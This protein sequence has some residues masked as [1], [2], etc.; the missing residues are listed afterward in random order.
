MSDGHTVVRGSAASARSAPALAAMAGALPNDEY[1]ADLLVHIAGV[2]FGLVG[3]ITLIG[4][5]AAGDAVLFASTAIY[6]LGLIAMLGCSCA[7][8]VSCPLPKTSWLR[9]ADHAA[10]FLMIAGSITPFALQ[11]EPAWRIA[12]LVLVW[13]IAL[14]AAAMKLL[15]PGRYEREMVYVYVALGWS[16]L[17]LLATRVGELPREAAV[18]LVTGVVIYTGG[19]FFHL[20]EKLR[21]GRA[22][23]HACVLAAAVCHYIAIRDGVVLSGLSQFGQA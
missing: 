13:S 3:A 12:G 1:L 7:Y 8:N 23:W 20:C 15:L 17:V 14:G 6:A 2:L 19:V 22:L 4:M 18:L 11:G 16:G 10:I 21:F 5:A 9:R